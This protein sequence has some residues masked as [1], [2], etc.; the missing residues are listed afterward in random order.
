[1]TRLPIRA[2]ALAALALAA[3]TALGGCGFTPLY[4][5]NGAGG[6]LAAIDVHDP[7]DNAFNGAVQDR[8]GFLLKQSLINELATKS[9][10]ARYALDT[11]I[12]EHR[13]PRGVRVNNVAN[14]YEINMTVAYKLTD[15]AS[16]KMVVEGKAPVIVTYDSADAPYAGTVAA[17]NGDER[18]TE[19]AAIQ[20]RLALGRYFAGQPLGSPGLVETPVPQDPTNAPP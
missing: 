10:T 5:T 19:Q 8:T 12:T 13:F 11:V 20:I 7:L 4:A 14:R 1:M 2:A 17:Q 16:G 15:L 3:A 6:S 18:A 9:G